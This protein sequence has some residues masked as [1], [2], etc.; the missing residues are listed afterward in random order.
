MLQDRKEEHIILAVNSQSSASVIDKR[1][2]YEPMLN[3]HPVENKTGFDFLGKKFRIPVWVSSMTGGSK[4]A[5][6][7]NRNL[8]KVCNDFGM[9]MGLGSCRTLLQSDEFLSDFN[10]RKI[11]GDDQAFYANLGISQIEQSLQN[12]TINKITDLVNKLDADGLIVHVNPL[13]EWFQ[14]EGDKLKSSP[15]ET[16]KRLVDNVRFKIIVKEVG[17]G[18]G[19]ESMSQL[20][21]MP[22][23]AIEFSA[24]G[25]TNFTSVELKRNTDEILHLYEPFSKIGN[26]AE[27]MLNHVNE[28]VSAENGIQCRQLIISGGI[29]N[30]LDGYY[31]INKSR[32]PAVYGQASALLEYAR[33][34]Y[35]S[36]YKFV[37]S[38]AKGLQLA[39]A[40]LKIKE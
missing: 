33:Q 4:I 19:P 34:S 1:F 31:F 2:F 36:L 28:Y 5:G 35:E 11:I 40:Y 21:K 30:F 12:N 18:I 13:Q 8:A 32:L 16:I 26:D 3:P 14:P 9:G 6:E 22:L 10:L 23:E 39:S 25:G 37:D 29:K 27:S 17:Q 15:I 20:L 24:F 38:Q 7:I